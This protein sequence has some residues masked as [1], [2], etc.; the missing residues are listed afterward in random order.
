[1]TEPMLSFEQLEVTK[2]EGGLNSDNS[3]AETSFEFKIV[4][5]ICLDENCDSQL[6]N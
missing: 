4:S 3:R 5:I 1:M 2:V 6:G